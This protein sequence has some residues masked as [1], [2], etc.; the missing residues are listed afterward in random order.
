MSQERLLV[1]IPCKD[2]RRIVE[3]C[4]P[5]VREGMTCDDRLS[6]YNDGSSE[7]DR[8][9][10]FDLGAHEVIEFNNGE[11]IGIERQ[12]RNHFNDFHW[13]M[14]LDCS[15]THL[16]LTD[17]DALHDPNWR[18]EAMRLQR[19][20]DGAPVCLYNTQAHSRLIGNTIEDDPAS[21]IIWRCVAPGI[22]YLLTTDH[23]R[24]VVAAIPHL[25]DPLH[26]D[27]SVPAILGHRMAV[28]RISHCDHLGW[29]GI[30]HPVEE[31]I[32]FGDR[33][34]NPTDWL[35]EKRKQVVAELYCNEQNPRP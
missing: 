33:A 34:T 31:G 25:P 19:L 7:Y 13:A 29:G 17:S 14:T 32:D 22:S 23:V 26:W 6:L 12:R 35:I 30:H 15:F 21:P 20:A 27:W 18:T 10:L 24:R 11:G 9:L 8:T 16:Y 4:I 2:R 3:Q 5:T 1:M 28:A